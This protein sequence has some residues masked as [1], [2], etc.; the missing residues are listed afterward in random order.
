MCFRENRS[1]KA[2]PINERKVV[3]K[4]NAIMTSESANGE[5]SASLS[6][7][8]PLLIICMFIAIKEA[9]ELVT[10]AGYPLQGEGGVHAGSWFGTCGRQLS[11]DMLPT[12]NEFAPAGAWWPTG[13]QLM[14]PGTEFNS[15]PVLSTQTL[16]LQVGLAR[17]A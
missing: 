17:R 12:V 3:G 5:S 10:L 13:I 7:S 4:E 11:R 9:N 1:A 16:F 15:V 8:Q 2:P 6:T 14:Y